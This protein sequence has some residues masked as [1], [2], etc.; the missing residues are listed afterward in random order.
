MNASRPSSMNYIF[1]FIVSGFDG[2]HLKIWRARG[3]TSKHSSFLL[4]VVMMVPSMFCIGSVAAPATLIVSDLPT[5][6]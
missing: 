1:I 2:S 4:S 6:V 3:D 5:G